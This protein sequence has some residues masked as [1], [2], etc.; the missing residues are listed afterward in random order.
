VSVGGVFQPLKVAFNLPGYFFSP[1][2]R[3]GDNVMRMRLL[4]T[5]LLVIAVTA[6]FAIGQTPQPA[7]APSTSD[8]SQFVK[9]GV[10]RVLI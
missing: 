5:A 1:K 4:C 7:A 3:K 2:T 6:N 10:T 9:A 8:I